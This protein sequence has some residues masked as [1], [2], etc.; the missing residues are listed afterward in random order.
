MNNAPGGRDL[1]R[2]A[3]AQIREAAAALDAHTRYQLLLAARAAEIALRDSEV[4][5]R[6][7][8]GEERLASLATAA[9]IRAGACDGDARVH[10]ALLGL[11]AANVYPTR[12]DMLTTEEAS[13][14]TARS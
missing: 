3:T 1:L 8:D 14:V 12:P 10:Q 13:A 11:T 6:L 4:A 7:R 2:A 5:S 9:A